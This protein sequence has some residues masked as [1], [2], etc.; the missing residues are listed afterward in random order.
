MTGPDGTKS[1]AYTGLIAPLIEA[2]QE[3][4]AEISQLRVILAVVFVATF[5]PTFLL[6]RNRKK[7]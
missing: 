5:F 3:Q 2:V 7:R 6:W 4:Q 1:L